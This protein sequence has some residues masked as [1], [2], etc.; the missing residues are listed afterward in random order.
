GA[1]FHPAATGS[2]AA[3]IEVDSDDS[4]ETTQSEHLMAEGITP[5]PCDFAAQPAS[6]QFGSVDVGKSARVDVVVTN[7]GTQECFI[8]GGGA[9]G[10]A[11]FSAVMPGSFPPPSVLAGGSVTVPVTYAPISSA[12]HSGQLIVKYNQNEISFG[13]DH[14]L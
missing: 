7:R 1:H 11:S 9:G 8:T 13:G 4:T 3:R 5:P 10:D 2:A 6:V 14:T 12:V